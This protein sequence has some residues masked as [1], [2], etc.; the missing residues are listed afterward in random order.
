M[1][2]E[3]G[4]GLSTLLL[5]LV[6]LFPGTPDFLDGRLVVNVRMRVGRTILHVYLH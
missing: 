5:L 4:W 6:S 2:R 3:V 1:Y